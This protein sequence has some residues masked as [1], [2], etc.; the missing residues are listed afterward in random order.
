M[1]ERSFKLN[2]A[3]TR[4]SRDSYYVNIRDYHGVFFKIRL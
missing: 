2:T 1:D 4:T 3:D